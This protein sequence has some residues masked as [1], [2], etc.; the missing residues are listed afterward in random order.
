MSRAPPWPLGTARR[1][2]E[3]G[4]RR[5]RPA[6]YV[7]DDRDVVAI[8]HPD[9]GGAVLT[10][11]GPIRCRPPDHLLPLPLFAK[12]ATAR[13]CSR[14]GPGAVHP[15][16][17]RESSD[18]SHALHHRRRPAGRIDGL[19]DSA[20]DASAPR[21]LGRRA[22]L[23]VTASARTLPDLT[24]ASPRW[25]SRSSSGS[26]ADPSCTRPVYGLVGHVRRAASP[27]QTSR[28]TGAAAAVPA[29]GESARR[30]FFA[31]R[32][33]GHRLVRLRGTDQQ[34][35]GRCCRRKDDR[36]ESP[37]PR[38]CGIF[39]CSAGLIAWLA[40]VPKARCSRRAPTSRPHRRRSRRRRR[41]VLDHHHSAQARPAAS[42]PRVTARIIAGAAGS[43]GHDDADRPSC[44]ATPARR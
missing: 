5:C 6:R 26:A 34:H 2:G 31:A 22:S 4:R 37:S 29:V 43:K 33:V 25:R 42:R 21:A 28:R 16:P 11:P 3:A 27:A 7:G 14:R 39:G 36:R 1:D 19:P 13:A 32:S 8:V 38:H 15:A 41:P 18:L 12:A 17:R 30:L 23:E 24:A 44:R 20:S 35:V 40:M 10:S 9:D